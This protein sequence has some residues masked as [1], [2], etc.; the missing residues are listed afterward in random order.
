MTVSHE[1]AAAEGYESVRFHAYMEEPKIQL[2]VEYWN[3][4]YEL[5]E[6]CC[7]L[8]LRCL[9]LREQISLPHVVEVFLERPLRVEGQ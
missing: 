4:A 5:P 2:F 3:T 1:I 7:A 9:F 8:E 6:L